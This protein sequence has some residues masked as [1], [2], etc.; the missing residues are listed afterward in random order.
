MANT[1]SVSVLADVKDMTRGISDINTKL[2]GLGKSAQ[3][4][5]GLVKGAF[6]VAGATAAANFLGDAVKDAEEAEAITRTLAKTFEQMG[7]AGSDAFKQSADAAGE[8]SKAIG[9]DDG[10]IAKVQTKLSTFGNVW[11][12]PIAGADN[13]KRATELAF[14][15]AAAGFGSADGNAVQLG[16]ALNDPIKGMSALAKSGVTFTDAEKEK[17]KRLQESGDLLGAQE[18][19][20]KAIEGQV[21]GAAKANVTAS[22]KMETALGEVKE[23]IGGALLPAFESLS[24][25]IVD[26]VAPAFQSAIA[27]VKENADLFKVLAVVVGALVAGYYAY[28]AVVTVISAVTKVW[29]GIQAALNIV[30]SLNPIGLVVLAIAALVAAVIIAYKN[31]EKFREIVTKAWEVIKATAIG[32]FNFIKNLVMAVFNGLK[33]YFT[34]MFNLYKTIFT[35]AWNAIAKVISTV[36]EG[37]KT[38]VKTAIEKVTGF[39]TGIKDKVVGFFSGAKNWLLDA[40][41]NIITGLLKGITDKFEAVKNF[42]GGIGSWIAENKGPKAYDLG[43]LV[44]N[45]K[46]L[47]QGLARGINDGYGMVQNAVSGIAPSIQSDFGTPMLAASGGAGGGNTYQINVTAIDPQSASKAVVDAIK[48][49]ERSNGSGWRK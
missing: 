46:W 22:M 13:F 9:I 42:V 45:G 12:D 3:K 19:L 47:M 10:E 30:M 7:G 1:I 39:V 37:I 32:V 36:W 40:G 35:T 33:A 23:S 25:F 15:L 6:L 26:T 2:G 41:K 4:M 17:I 43:L 31:S 21:G 18:I 16:K 44:P 11:K 49:Y 29:T 38:G 8:L 20:Y 14:D 27:F 34:F 5:G 24:G 48:T 28:Q